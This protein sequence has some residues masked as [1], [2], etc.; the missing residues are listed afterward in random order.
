MKQR[1]TFPSGR[2]HDLVGVL[3]LPDGG[4]RGAV[5]LAHCFTCSKDVTAMTRLA[6]SLAGAGF[7]ALRFDFSGLGESEG[8]FAESTVSDDIEDVVAAAAA[9]ASRGLPPVALVGHSL[10]GTVA[11]LAA[12]RIASVRAVAVVNAPSDPSHL[13]RHFTAVAAEVRG[14]GCKD[15]RLAGRP[16]PISAAFLDDLSTHD[17]V[18]RIATLGRP[19]LVVHAEDDEE[20]PLAEAEAIAAA[21][22][23]PV[24]LVRIPGADHLLW[25]REGAEATV[26]AVVDWL[27]EVVGG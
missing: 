21:A 12:G 20:V 10:G 9:L 15:V 19:L 14:R 26:A 27:D 23:G 7:A 3:H 24:R 6:R 13:A 16:M 17:T 25:R 18:G 8:S 2:G 22:S 1:L 4:G 5:V 11:L